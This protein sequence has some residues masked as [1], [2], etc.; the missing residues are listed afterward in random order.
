ME[1]QFSFRFYN[2]KIALQ[3]KFEAD[4][5]HLSGLWHLKRL[6]G[7]RHYISH[8]MSTCPII[9]ALAD[10]NIPIEDLTVDGINP[11]IVES[12]AR[13]KKYTKINILWM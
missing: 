10:N 9:D 6:D 1:L 8:R 3:R 7:V 13:L 2:D 11:C 4:V 5:M 12:L